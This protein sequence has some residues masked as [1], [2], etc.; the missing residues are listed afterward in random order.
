M[1][2]KLIRNIISPP[3]K[4]LNSQKNTCITW[5]IWD[6]F[7]HGSEA[8]NKNRVSPQESSQMSLS[9]GIKLPFQW[10]ELWLSPLTAVWAVVLIA[11]LSFLNLLTLPHF[12][13]QLKTREKSWQS[14]QVMRSACD[15]TSLTGCAPCF[16]CRRWKTYLPCQNI[17]CWFPETNIEC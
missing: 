9:D 3:A 1:I 17:F 7:L 10:N 12:L 6:W 16:N 2:L 13:K 15:H 8:S 4:A 11:A 5:C 14:C